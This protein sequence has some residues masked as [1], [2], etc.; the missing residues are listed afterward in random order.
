MHKKIKIK[1]NLF[2]IYI[3]LLYNTFKTYHISSI[4]S[5]SLSGMNITIKPSINPYPPPQ[6]KYSIYPWIKAAPVDKPH[7]KLSTHFFG[8]IIY[9]WISLSRTW[10]SRTP[11]LLSRTQ[12]RSPCPFFYHLLSA[13]SNCFLFPW[14]FKIAGF[15]CSIKWRKLAEEKIKKFLPFE[16]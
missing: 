1:L 2:S 6:F 13:I 14:V 4:Y 16:S 9:S 12:I 8:K 15:N 5:S 7:P 3:T 11:C 10:L